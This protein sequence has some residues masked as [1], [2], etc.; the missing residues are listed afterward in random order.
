MPV[1]DDDRQLPMFPDPRVDLLIRLLGDAVEAARTQSAIIQSLTQ[2]Q[3]QRRNGHSVPRRQHQPQNKALREWHTF[4]A[5]FVTLERKVRRDH[6][7]L[8]GDEVGMEMLY[9]AGG[10]PP[11]TMLRHMDY[12]GLRHNQ[13]PP[14]TWPEQ[15][16][17]SPAD[18]K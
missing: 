11:K 2:G 6:G 12:H 16:P 10:P 15:P 3:E 4:R 14:S 8:P 1:A 17:V 13:W 5:H 7:L 9:A 18:K